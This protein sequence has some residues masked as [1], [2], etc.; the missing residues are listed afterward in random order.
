MEGSY[1]IPKNNCYFEGYLYNYEY[2]IVGDGH[3]RGK[4]ELRLQEPGGPLY[5][6]IPIVAWYEVAGRL[7]EVEE[8]SWIKV[9]SNYDLNEFGGRSYPQFIVT[10]FSVV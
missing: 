3:P 8:G 9:L 5:Q 10:A 7:L 6:K 4:G 2:S 1:K